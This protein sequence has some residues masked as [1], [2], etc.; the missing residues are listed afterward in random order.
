M[1]DR[2]RWFDRIAHDLR[3][4]LSPLQ[5]AAWLLKSDAERLDPENAAAWVTLAGPARGTERIRLGTLVSAATFRCPRRWPSRW[6]RST[7]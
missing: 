5:T 2:S 3:G 6:R 4:P 1:N 7:R